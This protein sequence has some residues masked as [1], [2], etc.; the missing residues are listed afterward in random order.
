MNRQPVM[1]MD[2]FP[3]DFMPIVQPIDTWFLSRKLGMLFEAEVEGGKL[4]VSTMPYSDHSDPAQVTMT[5]AILRYMSSD[6]FRPAQKVELA[7][8]K[9]LFTDK[10]PEVNLFT[11]DNPDELK[12]G[13]R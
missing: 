11:N 4:M 3:K 8:L 2:N 9:Q 7:T 12:K 1:L 6:E 13:V 5:Q 10:T